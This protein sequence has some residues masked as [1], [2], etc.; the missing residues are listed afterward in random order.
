MRV[1]PVN[2]LALLLGRVLKDVVQLLAQSVLLVLAGAAFGLRAPILGILFGFVLVALMSAAL[3][4]LSYALAMRVTSP[5][6]F[7]PVVNAINLPVMLLSGI[8]LPMSLAPGWLDGISRAVPPRYVVEAIRTA[9][10]GEYGHSVV[11][12]ALAAITLAAASMT[13]AV[14]PFG[15]G[16]D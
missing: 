3:S 4:S 2:R 1:T 5:Q 9:F 12:G 6:E 15:S 7:A 14:R 16:R 10:V 8:L 13:L 11:I